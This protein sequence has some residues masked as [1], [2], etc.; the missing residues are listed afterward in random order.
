[1]EINTVGA[2]YTFKIKGKL[3]Y[4]EYAQQ[5]H[6]E[7]KVWIKDTH[8]DLIQAYNGQYIESATEAR[9]LLKR[10]LRPHKSKF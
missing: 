7:V 6:N 4:V 9:D 10:T 3:Y 8:L 5:D 2:E 1:M